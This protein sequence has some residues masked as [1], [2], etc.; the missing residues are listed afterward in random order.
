MIIT[1]WSKATWEG[2][3]LLKA[4]SSWSREVRAGAK[5]KTRSHG[6]VLLLASSSSFL[7]FFIGYFLYLHF[8]C[9]PLSMF[10][11]IRPLYYP[12]SPLLWKCYSTHPPTPTSLPSVP[13]YWGIYQ[14]ELHWICRLLS[15][16]WPFFTLLFLPIHEHGRSFDL[17]R[18]SISFFRDWKFYHTDLSL[19]WLEIFHLL[20]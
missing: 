19:A 11:P 8:K 18:S 17:L 16:G 5:D 12:P 15:A 4:Y 2:K 13:I 10:P 1:P 9:Y 7:L 3:G 20:G 14:W 6:R